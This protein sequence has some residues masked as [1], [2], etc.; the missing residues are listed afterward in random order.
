MS[1]TPIA[2]R[3]YNLVNDGVGITI[4]PKIL[5]PGGDKLW[6]GRNH[7]GYTV[8]VGESR[9]VDLTVF[10]I[11]IGTL[12]VLSES[13]RFG[14]DETESSQVFSFDPTCTVTANEVRGG[15][16]CNGSLEYRH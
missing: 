1:S 4:F 13:T 7:D 3:Y 2:T 10:G 16:A 11:D 5:T 12:F 14:E 8:N 9:S 15:S 6:D